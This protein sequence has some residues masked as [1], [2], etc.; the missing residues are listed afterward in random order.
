MAT[1]VNLK[2]DPFETGVGDWQKAPLYYM[3]ALAGPVTG[4]LYD[5]NMLPLGQLMWLKELESYKQFPPLQPPE[6][7]NLDQVIAEVKNAAGNPSH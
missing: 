6:S 5:W 1:V 2:R 7:W 4:Y 3:G